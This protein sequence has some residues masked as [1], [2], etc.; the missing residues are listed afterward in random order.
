[1]TSARGLVREMHGYPSIEDIASVQCEFANGAIGTL[2]SVWHDILERP[3]MRRVEMFCENL[4]IGLD[5]DFVG[6]VRCRFTGE[7]EQVVKGE[8]LNAVLSIDVDAMPNPAT[9]FL[10]AIGAGR[11]ADPRCADALR[12]HDVVDAIYASAAAGG[13][14]VRV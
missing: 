2:M 14:V 8:S 11:P 3:S 12:A 7:D 10:R 4:Y 9:E 13:T 5:G 6:P 1:M